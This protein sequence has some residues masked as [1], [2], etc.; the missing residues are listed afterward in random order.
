MQHCSPMGIRLAT[1]PP[2]RVRCEDC[3]GVGTLPRHTLSWWCPRAD[4]ALR[5]RARV[6]GQARRPVRP[7]RRAGR[8]QPAARLPAPAAG[9]RIAGALASWMGPEGLGPSRRFERPEILSLLR[10]PVPPRPRETSTLAS[11][12]AQPGTPE[13]IRGSG[14]VAAPD[15][16]VARS[17]TACESLSQHDFAKEN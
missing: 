1:R 6:S 9:P 16:K 8:R 4:E 10:L 14:G 2:Y 5:L 13:H 17:R 15:Q 12:T 11:S 7:P 3:G